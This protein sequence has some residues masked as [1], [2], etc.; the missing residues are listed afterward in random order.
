MGACGSTARPTLTNSSGAVKVANKPELC[1]ENQGVS[2]KYLLYKSIQNQDLET[3]KKLHTY[4]SIDPNEEIS[5]KGYFWTAIHY[6]AFFGSSTQMEFLIKMLYVKNQEKF[7]DIL[8]LQTVEKYTPLMIAAMGGKKLIVEMLL[9]AGGVKLDMVDAKGRT[10]KD[11]AKSN[12]KTT[13]VDIL[14]AKESEGVKSI[15][16]NKDFFKNADV[17]KQSKTKAR[18]LNDIDEEDP[19]I[20]ELLIKGKRIPCVIC[21]ENNGLIQYTECCGQPLHS[22][23]TNEKIKS[24]PYCKATTL[25][26]INDVLYPDRAFEL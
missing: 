24:C 11:L 19:K 23:C 6:A 2:T 20:Q 21:Q 3:T 5:V 4:F 10:A 22:F 7:V 26:L 18:T 17:E 12:G 25:T 1:L 15:P 9:K 14:E 16:V 8:N 13:C